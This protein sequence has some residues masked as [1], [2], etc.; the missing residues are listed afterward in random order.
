MQRKTIEEI[1]IKK[2][3]QLKKYDKAYFE[4]DKPLVA[5][6]IYDEV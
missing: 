2:I 6:K 1:Y 5:D 4:K 3:N